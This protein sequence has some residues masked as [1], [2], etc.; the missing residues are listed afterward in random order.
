MILQLLELNS[1]FP[2]FSHNFA[3]KKFVCMDIVPED[4]L[5][6]ILLNVPPP[7]L[8]HTVCLVSKQFSAIIMNKNYLW[9]E[10]CKNRYKQNV[11]HILKDKL[12]SATPINWKRF[13]FTFGGY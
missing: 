10:L 5:Q 1:S 12:S 8:L 2:I 6:H 7:E 3:H 4:I 11:E 9:I 13:F